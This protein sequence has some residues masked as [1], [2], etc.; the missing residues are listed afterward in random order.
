[1]DVFCYF[2]QN[3]NVTLPA[4]CV[5]YAAI[6]TSS[7]VI[8]QDPAVALIFSPQDLEI[9]VG[10][11]DHLEDAKLELSPCLG[12]VELRRRASSLRGALGDVGR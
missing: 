12:T 3:P 11:F 7:A 2:T 9:I 6:E 5:K 4:E 1:M 8:C 10:R